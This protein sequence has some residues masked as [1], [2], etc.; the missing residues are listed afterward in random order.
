MTQTASN[1][2]NRTDDWNNHPFDTLR[3]KWGEVPGGLVARK[4]TSEL[5]R[6]SDD[7]LLNTWHNARG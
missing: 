5:L 7:E 6:V 1:A 4:K 3:K 2:T